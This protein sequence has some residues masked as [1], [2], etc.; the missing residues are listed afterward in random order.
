MG[1]S[2]E[3]PFVV[4]VPK[5]DGHPRTFGDFSLVGPVGL[6]SRVFYVGAMWAVTSV[7][8]VFAYVKFGFA[9]WDYYPSTGIQV[10]AEGERDSPQIAQRREKG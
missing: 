7:V 3:E 1:W 4:N 2:R 10:A 8:R 5:N 6:L 9:G